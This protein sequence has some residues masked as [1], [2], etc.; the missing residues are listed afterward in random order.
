M[1]KGKRLS[2]FGYRIGNLHRLYLM[3][4]RNAMADI[5]FPPS[6][7]PFI[8]ELYQGD[9]ISQDVLSSRVNMD[10]GTT[11]RAI[12]RLECKGLVKRS[13]NNLNRR[14]KLVYLTPKAIKMSNTFFLPL[15]QM[16]R[17]MS[18]GFSTQERKQLLEAFDLMTENLQRGLAHQNMRG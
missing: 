3:G 6:L 15:Y 17:V 4:V 7:V 16:S 5:E 14:Q 12:A 1:V 10:K 13:E 11:A 2:A 9:G 18:K 8:T